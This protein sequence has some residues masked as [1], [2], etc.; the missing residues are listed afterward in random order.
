[1]TRALIFLSICEQRW[2]R[3]LDFD[4]AWTIQIAISLPAI[5]IN[6]VATYF[7]RDYLA[8]GLIVLCFCYCYVRALRHLT[9]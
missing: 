3:N 8:G 1:M 4:R 2:K 6:L 7:W 5:I 9:K